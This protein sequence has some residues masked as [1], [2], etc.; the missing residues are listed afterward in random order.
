[1]KKRIHQMMKPTPMEAKLQPWP[2]RNR[3]ADVDL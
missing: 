3:G 2:R 1:M